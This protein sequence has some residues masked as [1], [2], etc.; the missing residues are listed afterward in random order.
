MLHALRK[1][2][3][4]VGQKMGLGDAVLTRILS[5]TAPKTDA[6]N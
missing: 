4:T 5:L 1:M 3:A 6:L 2:V